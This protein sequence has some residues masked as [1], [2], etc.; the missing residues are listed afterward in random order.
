VAGKQNPDQVAKQLGFPSAASMIAWQ[1]RQQEIQ[2]LPA[3][4]MS[5]QPKAQQT[6]EGTGHPW[7]D[8]IINM[9]PLGGALKKAGDAMDGKK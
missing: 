1:H 5:P 2:D 6:P 3:Q 8:A 4:T 7:L 9:L